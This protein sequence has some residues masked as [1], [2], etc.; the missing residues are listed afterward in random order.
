MSKNILNQRSFFYKTIYATIQLS[1]REE[2]DEAAKK[3]FDAISSGKVK[4]KISKKY[5]LK[6]V[7]KAH[8]ILREEKFYWTSSNNS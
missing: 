3:V 1:T 6:E 5:S 4:I 2:L 8:K 7:I